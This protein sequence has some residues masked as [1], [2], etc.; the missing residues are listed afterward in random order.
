MTRTTNARIAGFTFLFYIAVAFPSMVLFARATSGEGLAAKLAGIAQHATDLR[1]AVVLSLGGCFSALVLAVTLYAITRDEDPDLAMLGL[2][3]RVGEGLIGA[4]SV[5][6]TVAL[7]QIATAT[8]PQAPDSAATQALAAFV[9]ERS[10][11]VSA[12]FFAVGSTLFAWLLLRGR[13]IPIAL[14]RLGVLASVLLGVGLPLQLAGVLH[15]RVTQLMWIPMAAFE[16]PLG[17]WLL[18]KG[19]S[20]NVRN[21]SGGMIAGDAA[22]SPRI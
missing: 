20:P 18:F 8:G 21:S 5:P 13:V 22:R 6:A 10:P 2:T 4:A 11:L 16:I 17:F 1:L 9:L 14:A 12:L 15:G 3:C 19:V 7:L